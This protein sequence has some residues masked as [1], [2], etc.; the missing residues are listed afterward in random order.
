MFVIGRKCYNVMTEFLHIEVNNEAVLR[1]LGI[2][3]FHIMLTFCEWCSIN[4][5]YITTMKYPMQIAA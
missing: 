2:N 4:Q 5:L 1:V 3:C